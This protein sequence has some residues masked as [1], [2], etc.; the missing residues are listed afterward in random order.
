MTMQDEK[1][2]IKQAMQILGSRKSFRKAAAARA[3][4]R[5]GG[6]PRKVKHDAAT[7]N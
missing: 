2:I 7:A 6:R 3:N 5:L 1:K 4:G